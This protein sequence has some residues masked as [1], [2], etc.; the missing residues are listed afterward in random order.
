MVELAPDGCRLD[1]WGEDLILDG[2]M[3]AI[4][5]GD[6]IHIVDRD[7]HE[8]VICDP[9]GKRIGGIGRRHH[10]GE[11]FNHPTDVAFTPAGETG[12]AQC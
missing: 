11:R 7:C 9:S 10:P 1:A 5:A 2:H 6:R 8:T 12:P 3:L 4:D